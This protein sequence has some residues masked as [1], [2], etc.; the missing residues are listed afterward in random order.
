MLAIL[1]RNCWVFALDGV[2]AIIFGILAIVWPLLTLQVLILLFGSYAL[3][4][5]VFTVIGGIVAHERNQHLWMMLLEGIAGI[6]IGILA[7]R[8]PGTNA[9]ILLY[10]IA[11]WGIVTGVLEIVAAIRLRRII[12]FDTDN[13]T[14]TQPRNHATTQ[15]RNHAGRSMP[16]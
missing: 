16:F 4:D 3:V 8:W 11:A 1:A 15:P 6:I 12:I 7:F 5:G 9:L 10:F 13:R 2:V 14:T